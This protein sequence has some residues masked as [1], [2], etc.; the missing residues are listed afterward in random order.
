MVAKLLHDCGVFL[1][2]ED[3]LNQAA[4]DN[5]EGYFENRSFVILNEDILTQF[6]GTWDNPPIFPT[7]WE[8]SSETSTFVERAESL[9]G[10]CRHRCWGWKDPRNSLTLPFWVRLIRE[11]KVIIC[12]RNP[13]EVTRSLFVRGDLKNASQFQLWLNYYRQLLPVIRPNQRLV[14]HYRS[15]FHSP[16]QELRRLL[17]WLDLK[18]SDEAVERAC[19]QISFGLRHHCV[20]TAE[21]IDADVPDEVL[22]LYFDLCSE[23]GPVCQEARRHDT[24]A[25]LEHTEG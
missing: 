9:M 13:L 14:T 6:D 5:L 19:T 10:Q 8:L 17:D 16:C 4:P 21:L 2:P 18:V 1:G 20:T 15:Y 23:A 25:E 12:V 11:L 24:A 3:E 7:G 22:S